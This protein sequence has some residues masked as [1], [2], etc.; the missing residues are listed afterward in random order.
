MFGYALSLLIAKSIGVG[1]SLYASA[2]SVS[3]LLA[4]AILQDSFLFFTWGLLLY[5]VASLIG[6]RAGRVLLAVGTLLSCVFC[7]ANGATLRYF[8]REFI[9]SIGDLLSLNVRLADVPYYATQYA[10]GLSAFLCIAAHL[11][12]GFHFC[13]RPFK[14]AQWHWSVVGLLAIQSAGLARAPLIELAIKRLDHADQTFTD[15]Y[16]YT[17]RPLAV[18]QHRPPERRSQL[19]IAPQTVILFINESLSRFFPSSDGAST[20]LMAK[21]VAASSP[22][23]GAW[24]AF[25][26]AKTNGTATEI[27]VPSMLTGVDPVEESAKLHAM[28]FVF[29][30]AHAAGYRTA[31]FTSQDY[32]WDGFDDFYRPARIETYVTGNNLPSPLPKVNDTG[33][34]D[35]EIADRVA[36]YVRHLRTDERCFLVINS[37]ALHVPF[38]TTSKIPLPNT[39]ARADQ[40]AA[41]ILESYYGRIFAALE[42]AGRL[43]DSLMI[44]TS[45]H[46]DMDVK[47]HRS[48]DRVGDHYDEVITVPF[49]V[50]LP[51]QTAPQVRER[52]ALNAEKTVANLD[53]APTLAE[54]FGY[55]PPPGLD[56]AGFSLFSIVP[57][58]RIVY[59]LTSNEWK[60]WSRPA[61]SLSQ[62]TERFIFMANAGAF[63]FDVARDPQ[64]QH[65]V[66]H[67]ERYDAFLQRAMAVPLLQDMLLQL[68]IDRQ[69]QPTTK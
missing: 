38:Q 40:K 18:S 9:Q 30:L 39:L 60:Q 17:F 59:C 1:T 50:H 25:P 68:D 15:G 56:Y 49:Y 69:G 35:M 65:G 31:F 62:G 42:H 13:R 33:I 7:L 34:D 48:V 4:F 21:I 10:S 5:Q 20:G 26:Y 45:D 44:V 24:I 6:P 36:D 46:G 63:W 58:D 52:M 51:V 22:K 41:F 2:A 27:S 32:S 57:S 23:A 28:P 14:N 29:D 43:A 55:G 64:E 8:N 47:R 19:G 16:T 61:F 37:N 12:V 53:I 11:L 66:T 67:G 3:P 54:I